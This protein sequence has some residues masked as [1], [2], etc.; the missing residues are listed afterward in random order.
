[1]PCVFTCG[2]PS[3]T[4]SK[5]YY[6]SQ[7]IRQ[8]TDGSKDNPKDNFK[9]NFKDNLKDNF[10]DNLKDN[11]KDNPKDLKGSARFSSKPAPGG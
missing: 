9:D 7:K 2:L 10:K 8:T 11:L 5:H 4:Q 6:L 3:P 1:M